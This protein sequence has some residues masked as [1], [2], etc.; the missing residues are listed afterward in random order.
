MNSKHI[1]ALTLFLWLFGCTSAANKNNNPVNEQTSDAWLKTKIA[2]TYALSEHLYPFAI[3]VAV[4]NG[5]AALSGTVENTIQRDLAGEIAKDVDGIK[6][7]DNRLH[8]DPEIR[9]DPERGLFLRRVNDANITARVRSRLLTDPHT[10]EL[11]IHVTTRNGVAILEGTVASDIE[12]DLA[13]QIVLNT[14][15]VVDVENNLKVSDRPPG[16]E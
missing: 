6:R 16:G 8:V 3:G 5:V 2:T 14:K 4:S 9:H 15:G 12:S 1:A 7:V 10:Q 11:K 13:Q